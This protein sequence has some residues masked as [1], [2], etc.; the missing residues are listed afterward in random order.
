MSCFL[1]EDLVCSNISTQA[2]QPTNIYGAFYT[3]QMKEPDVFHAVEC[4]ITPLL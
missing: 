3:D 2:H 4:K 1:T